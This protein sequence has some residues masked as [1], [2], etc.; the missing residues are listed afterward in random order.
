MR[1]ILLWAHL[2]IMP[3]AWDNISDWRANALLLWSR[4]GHIYNHS[5]VW[6]HALITIS[7]NTMLSHFSDAISSVV[8]A[9]SAEIR[10]LDVIGHLYT[11][12]LAMLSVG[13]DWIHVDW[14]HVISRRKSYKP[15]WCTKVWDQWPYFISH[16][17]LLSDWTRN[18][19]IDMI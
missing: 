11:S 14:M 17:F 2:D 6:A 12:G 18:M 8:F 9:Q 13:F 16:K 5:Y 19:T 15:R 4:P 1:E 7:A 3:S 10:W